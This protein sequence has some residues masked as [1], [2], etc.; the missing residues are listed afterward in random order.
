M[1]EYVIEVRRT[2]SQMAVVVAVFLLGAALAGREGAVFGVLLG[3]VA[4]FIY[5]LQ[6][7]YRVKRSAGMPPDKAVTYMQTGWI[8]RLFLILLVATLGL[9][10][11][12]I[13]FPAVVIGLFSLH[14][15]IVFNAVAVVAKSLL[16]RQRNYKIR[17]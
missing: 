13:D 6:M 11:E 14:I 16:T 7:C 8:V 1:N 15:V 4:S 2:L 5:F 10:M 3:G 9:K 12:Q 17:E